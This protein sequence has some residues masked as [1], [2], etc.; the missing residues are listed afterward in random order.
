MLESAILIYCRSGLTWSRPRADRGLSRPTSVFRTTIG[1]CK[2]LSKSVEIWQ[3][4]GQKA[5]FS[6]NRE[7]PSRQLHVIALYSY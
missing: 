1:V 5:V 6:K 3:Y 4:E 2:I 7:R